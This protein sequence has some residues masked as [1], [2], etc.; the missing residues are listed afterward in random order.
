MK[1]IELSPGRLDLV[2]ETSGLPHTRTNNLGMF[3]D[4]PDCE[5]ERKSQEVFGKLREFVNI[6]VKKS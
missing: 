3:C 5:C 2:C 1:V 4:A 6:A